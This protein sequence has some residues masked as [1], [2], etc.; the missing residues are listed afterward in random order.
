VEK[1]KQKIK[2]LNWASQGIQTS[3]QKKKK[4]RENWGRKKEKE[5][6]KEKGGKFCICI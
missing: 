3:S 4:Q 1:T 2:I 6:E 5:K